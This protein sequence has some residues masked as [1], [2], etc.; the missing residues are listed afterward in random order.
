MQDKDLIIEEQKRE[1][2]ELRKLKTEFQRKG[3][4]EELATRISTRFINLPLEEIESNLEA[5][6]KEI[7][8]FAGLE[9]CTVNL[10]PD[11]RRI[12]KIYYYGVPLKGFDWQEK[13]DFMMDMDISQFTWGYG[14][15]K[16][17]ETL[18]V[19]DMDLL[20]PEA[21]EDKKAWQAMGML[22]H[23]TIPLC[24]KNR[25]TGHVAF[26]N[27]TR[28]ISYSKE[29]LMLLKLITEIIAG[30]LDRKDM[31]ER[32]L[33]RVGIEHLVTSIS[34]RFISIISIIL[35]L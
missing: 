15:L 34:S 4:I 25:L 10:Y 14:K 30:V 7:V 23:L 18:Y 3:K 32:I 2:E 17:F 5:S 19:P 8:N 27:S 29:E 1:I 16:N 20:P 11:G 33:Y 21:E 26:V 24:I 12:K 35:S 28:A 13:V 22:S 6:L 9:T 31:E